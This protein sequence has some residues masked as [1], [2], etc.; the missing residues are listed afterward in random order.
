M[1]IRDRANGE[2]QPTASTESVKYLGGRLDR[3]LNFNDQCYISD[4]K[5]MQKR[6]GSRPTLRGRLVF[7]NSIVFIYLYLQIF[8][9][10]VLHMYLSLIHI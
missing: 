3:R 2:H 6:K 1:C 4:Q 10:D 9:Y 7:M 5:V 8:T